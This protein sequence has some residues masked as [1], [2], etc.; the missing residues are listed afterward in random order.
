VNTAV[1]KIGNIMYSPAYPGALFGN[2][3][4]AYGH[5]LPSTS[6]CEEVLTDF[7]GYT[8]GYPIPNARKLI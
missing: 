4:V 8:G 2:M 3:S 1:G 6:T 7:S 5:D